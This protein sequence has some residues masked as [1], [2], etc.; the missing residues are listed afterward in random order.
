M[1]KQ[2]TL[3]VTKQEI[4]NQLFIFFKWKQLFLKRMYACYYNFLLQFAHLSNL[5]VHDQYIQ[6]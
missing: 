1:Y 4:L 6:K 2:S 5:M 3:Q